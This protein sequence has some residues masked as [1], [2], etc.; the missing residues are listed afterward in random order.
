MVGSRGPCYKSA[1]LPTRCFRCVVGTVILCVV[2]VL[3]LYWFGPIGFVLLLG[4]GLPSL[5]ALIFYWS[6]LETRR[7]RGV[8]TLKDKGF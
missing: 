1:M 8:N 7:G 5:L 3:A 2:M 4:I 6:D